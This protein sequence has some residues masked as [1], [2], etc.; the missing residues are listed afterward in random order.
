MKIS[1]SL[2]VTMLSAVIPLTTLLWSLNLPRQLGLN[3]FTEQMLAF[4]VALALP[5]TFLTT[6]ARASQ[7]SDG[8]PRPAIDKVSALVS[9]FATA[10]IAVRYPQIFDALY[11]RPLDATISGAVVIVLLLEAL[12][13]TTGAFLAGIVLFFLIYALFGHLVPGELQ[14]RQVALDRLI[15]YVSM[16]SNGLM[17]M[18]L[19]VSAT[20]VVM[21]VLFG[22][23]LTKSGGGEF[24][25]D[26]ATA[27]MGRYR[28]GSAKI[29]I[30]ASSLFGSISGSAVA[31]VASTGV[32]T[33]PL[34]K[35]SGYS[36]RSAAAIESVASTGGQMMPPVMGAAAFLMAELLQVGYGVIITAALLPAILY[37]VSL[38]AQ[39]DLIAARDDIKAIDA[40]GIPKAAS[41]LRKGGYFI[42]PFIVLILSMF[43]FGVTPLRAVFYA[44]VSLLPLAAVFSYSGQRA[45]LNTTWTAL[46]NAG[47]SSAKIILIGAAAGIIIGVLNITSL[48][49]ALTISLVQFAQGQLWILLFLAAG[50]SIILGMGM[51]TVGVYILLATMVAPTLTEL[52][53]P[54]IAAHLFVLY[55]GMMS[56][57]TPP[58]AIAAFTASI[59]AKSPPL[60]TSLKAATF[61]WAAY[62]I[63]FVF[64]FE[65]ALLLNGSMPEILLAGSRAALGVWIVSAC[66]VGFCN[67]RLGGIRR[68][69]FAFVGIALL[70]PAT[71]IP[72]G[73]IT[74]LA[75]L[76][77]GVVVIIIEFRNAP[78]PA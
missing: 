58:V 59:I 39:A 57:I 77:V 73:A 27:A 26:I 20:T 43:M 40:A 29:A 55:F 54:E 24:F 69:A 19:R 65:P 63:P 10:Y 76:A 52:G 60:T 62:V 70:I 11:E 75:T 35:R 34:M 14:G 18:P 13:R 33:I 9:F 28:G 47:A 78:Q 53:V 31:N 12:R 64:V 56:M 4:M 67:T 49:F 16:D 5:L 15:V 7:D 66:F 36:A 50:L 37:Y 22:S 72:G 2:I 51:P 44:I 8:G 46:L 42:V 45:T 1:T 23:L 41:V 21:F 25:T 38:F 74:A 68:P 30:I 17:G 32:V 71:L 48:G 6:P 3:L 61:G